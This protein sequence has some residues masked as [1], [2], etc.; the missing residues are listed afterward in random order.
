MKYT[1]L[2]LAVLKVEGRSGNGWDQA[3][4]KRGDGWESYFFEK[5]KRFL[6]QAVQGD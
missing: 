1:G 4:Q 6:L 5:E 3:L 2:L